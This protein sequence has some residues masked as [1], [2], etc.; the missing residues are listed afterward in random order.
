MARPKLNVQLSN[1]GLGLRPPSEFGTCGV[2]IA[3]PVAPVAG[4]GVPFLVKTIAQAKTAFAQVGN[5][6]VVTAINDGFYAEAPE[7][8]KLYI[9]CMA[10]AT[11]LAT[12]A[13][14][15]NANKVLMLAGGDIRKLALIK[16]PGGSYVP[17]I[18]NGFDVDVHNAVTAAQTLA[19]IWF[20]KQQPFRVFVDGYGFVD[21]A[22]AK[23]Y[24]TASN[25]NVF[26]S[27][28][29][30]DGS[31]SR[32][33]M[34]AMG[35]ASAFDP[36][37]N[38]G[39]IKSGSLNIPETSIVKIGAISVDLMAD[40]DL[41]TLFEKRYIAPEK[42]QSDSGYV[43]SYDPALTTSTDDYNNLR[44]GS[45]ADN[46]TR[47]IKASYYKELKDDVDVE[48]GGRLSAVIEKSLENEIESAI[49]NNIRGQLSK[50]TDG[51]AAVRALV[52]PDPTQYAAL[53]S[54]NGIDTPNF[55]LLQTGTT[56]IFVLARP[57][58]SLDYINIYQGYTTE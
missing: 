9:M 11:A 34:L 39:R 38:I 4:Y 7:G 17:T 31:T 16:Y 47:V 14:P 53:Y 1:G 45:V 37:Q 30:I 50:N 46:I 22:S 49:D 15:V 32:A 33:T 42:N 12:L 26:I 28:Y 18:T 10:P 40:A 48:I 19:G 43:F 58:G 24:S 56:Y 2:L 41:D 6:D 29:N 44:Y 57:K 35:R 23:D 54:Q 55:N 52:N 25:R 20:A 36:Q 8:T 51:T 5:E 21:A 3:S 13:L 27:T